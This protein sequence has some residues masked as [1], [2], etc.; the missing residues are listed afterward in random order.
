MKGDTVIV[1]TYGGR[2]LV[3]RIWDV[4][5]HAVYITNDEQFHLL[6]KGTGGLEPLGFPNEDVFEYSPDLVKNMDKLYESGKW[7]WDNLVLWKKS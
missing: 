6:I 5:E 1:R 7:K 3:R 2:P 4:D